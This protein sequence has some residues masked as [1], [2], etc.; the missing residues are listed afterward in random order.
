[1]YADETVTSPAKKD[2]NSITIAFRIFHL[3]VLSLVKKKTYKLVKK[4]KRTKLKQKGQTTKTRKLFSLELRKNINKHTQTY[5]D[6]K[7]CL[8]AE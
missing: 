1:M 8:R 7:L 3:S 4:K 6:S 5:L 2:E